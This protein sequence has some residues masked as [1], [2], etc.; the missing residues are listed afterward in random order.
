MPG[1]PIY[2]D[3]IKPSLPHFGGVDGH[4]G[5]VIYLIPFASAMSAIK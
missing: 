1:I 2:N 4:I 5:P 3:R